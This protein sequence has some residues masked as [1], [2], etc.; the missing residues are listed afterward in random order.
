MNAQIRHPVTDVVEQLLLRFHILKNVWLREPCLQ[1][2]EVIS[3][4][5]LI[6]VASLDWFRGIVDPIAGLIYAVVWVRRFINLLIL[7]SIN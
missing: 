6:K 4:R 5:I 7:T 1:L 3:R 2:L